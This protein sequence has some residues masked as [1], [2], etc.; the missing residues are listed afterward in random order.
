MSK[1]LFPFHFN[2]LHKFTNSKLLYLVFVSVVLFWL[3]SSLVNVYEISHKVTFLE[4]TSSIDTLQIET[5]Y[6]DL[7]RRQLF[8]GLQLLLSSYIS[9]AI[10][11]GVFLRNL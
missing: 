2:I 10:L 5:K 11:S 4:K 8:S 6:L 7:K 1:F 3:M 9:G